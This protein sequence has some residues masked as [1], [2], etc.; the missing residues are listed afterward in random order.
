MLINLTLAVLASLVLSAEAVRQPPTAP[1]AKL[2]TAK[3]ESL[4]RKLERGA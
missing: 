3:G 2:T 1:P 4:S